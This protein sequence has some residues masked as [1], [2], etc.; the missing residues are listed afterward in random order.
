ME[1]PVDPTPPPTPEPK[2]P[3]KAIPSAKF[4]MSRI[5]SSPLLRG[6]CHGPEHHQ[7]LNQVYQLM[8]DYSADV[9][10]LGP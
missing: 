2:E 7:M 9:A 4:L 3:A 5:R 6:E 8:R 1:I 10:A